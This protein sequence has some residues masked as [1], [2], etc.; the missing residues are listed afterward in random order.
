MTA[1]ILSNDKDVQLVKR[2]VAQDLLPSELDL[3]IHMCRQW[4]LDPLRR[5]IYAQVFKRKKKE[6]ND[7]IEVRNVV[8]VT[9]IDGYRSIADRTGN[10]RPGQRSAEVSEDARNPKTNPQGIVSATASVWKF[11]HGEWHEF[12][13]TVYWEEFAPLKAKWEKDEFGDKKPGEMTLDTSGQW[14]RMGRVM[15][16]K[17]AEGQALRR[18]WPDE[19]GDL[20]VSEEMDQAKII[21]ITP[22][23]QAERAYSETRFAMIGG[24]NAVTVDWC[25]G[26]A[27][28][29]VPAGQF[30]DQA[31]KYIKANNLEAEV[32][33]CGLQIREAKKSLQEAKKIAREKAMQ[34]FMN[35]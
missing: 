32:E 12:S 6:G 13:E 22:T 33:V 21:D 5:Q 20:Y 11:A 1:L 34:K 24:R 35:L 31:L 25:D 9:A 19:Y 16:Q 27:L 7:W 30:G 18:G 28:C 8:Y 29:R 23:E 10:Y 3:F 15:L 14:G 17:C 4:R 2:T 26:G